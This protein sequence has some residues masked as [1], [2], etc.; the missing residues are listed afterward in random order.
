MVDGTTYFFCSDHCLHRFAGA[1]TA[2]ATAAH[3]ATAHAA[4]AHA[5]PAPDGQCSCTQT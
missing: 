1:A 4:T 2:N 5:G 3:A